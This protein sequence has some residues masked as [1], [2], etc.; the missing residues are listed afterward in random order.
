MEEKMNKQYVIVKIE[1]EL[2]GI[3]IQFIDNIVKM[4]KVTRIPKS[5]SYLK[6]V[7][8]LRG[9]IIPIMSLQE[10]FGF[11]K[12]EFTGATRII[13]VKTE[14]KPTMGLL[15]D[16]VKEVIHLAMEEIE[17]N[18]KE[19]KEDAMHYVKGIGKKDGN[20]IS[21]LNLPVVLSEKEMK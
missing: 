4:Q 7:I 3:D 13:I 18:F 8:N 12:E 20:L 16:E 21:L 19:E 17:M 6:G 9:E 14:E 15:V 5:P 11:G 10:K 1:Q 2:Y